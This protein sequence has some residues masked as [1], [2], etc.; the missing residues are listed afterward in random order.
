MYDRLQQGEVLNKKKLAQEHGVNEKTIQRDLEDMRLY[1]E[2]TYRLVDV[3][4]VFD[5]QK[6]GYV[7]TRPSQVWLTNEEVLWLARILLESRSLPKKDLESFLDKLTMQCAPTD[8]KKI[9]DLVR[10]E[11]SHYIP[12]RHGRSLMK[13]VWALSQASRDQFVVEIEYQ[14]EESEPSKKRRIFP[15]GVL[16]SE[17]YFYLL[18]QIEGKPYDFPTIYRMDRIKAYTIM[19]EHF[20]VHYASRFEEGEFRKKIQFMQA[21]KLMKVKFRFWGESLEAILDRLPTAKILEQDGKVTVLQAETFG[22]GIKMWFLSQA[23]YLEV[24]EPQEFRE[25]MR[26]TIRNMYENY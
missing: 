15:Q 16:F 1:L 19:A 23:Q 11:A 18:A 7:L 5:R 4:I 22:R 21:G 17:Y 10:N 20:S 14:R 9:S 3:T 12:L 2:E 25:E 24:L 6:G 13:V 26:E 8:R